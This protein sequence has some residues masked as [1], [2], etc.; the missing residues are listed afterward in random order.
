LEVLSLGIR[1]T[2]ELMSK[3]KD[4]NPFRK[5]SGIRIMFPVIIGLGAVVFFFLKD[6]NP[7]IFQVLHFTKTVALF[8]VVAALFMV[9]RDI[10]Y[11]VRLRILTHNE[12]NW[13]Q[14]FK[15][16]MLWE[17][18][19]AVT[20]SAV[21]GTTIATLYVY[22]E[23][24]TLGRSTAVVMATSL[25]DEIYFIIM[26]PLLLL[27]I[28]MNDL[29]IVGS[30]NGDA[31]SFTNEFLWFAIIGYSLK[32]AYTSIVSYGLFVNPRGLKWLLLWI[33]KLP[34]LRKFRYDAHLTGTDIINSSKELK[35]Q[36]IWFW[37]KAF[38]ATSFSW[39]S[40]YWVVNA[41]FIAFFVVPDH[42]L[43]F[44]RQLVM[45][46]MML[47]SPTPG[48]SGFSEFIFTKYLGDFILVDPALLGGVAIAL[49]LIWRLL[50]Y[51][52]YLIAGAIILPG[53]IKEKFGKGDVNQPIL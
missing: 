43:L 36:S 32:L 33:F 35:E 6:F 30:H 8:L 51:Y 13:K 45:W 2:K 14:I 46:L 23:G 38:G 10:G 31:I 28:N 26:F 18:T 27:L 16:I 4:Q 50:S 29:F 47:V 17:F 20:P 22:K 53:W 7:D 24:I 34:I 21:G 1:K 11:M 39:T 15:I 52:P 41:L 49:A 3:Q 12:L 9:M 37:L 40:R 42:F 44:A 19:S 5:L 48:G 25:L